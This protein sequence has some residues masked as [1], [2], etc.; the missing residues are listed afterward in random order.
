MRRRKVIDEGILAVREALAVVGARGIDIETVLDAQPFF[1]PADAVAAGIVQQYQVDLAARK[2]M[3]RHTGREELGRIL[4]TC[5]RPPAPWAS[6][7]QSSTRS[8]P[9]SARM[10]AWRQSPRRPPSA[11]AA[12]DCPAW[13]YALGRRLESAS[14]LDIVRTSRATPLPASTTG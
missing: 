2:I 11:L 14:L 6:R 7:R 8:S 5:W 12:V 4:A 13:R 3:T 10:Q 1:G 9:R